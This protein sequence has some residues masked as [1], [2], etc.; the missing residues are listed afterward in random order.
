MNIET[1]Y[2]RVGDANIAYQVIG[3]GAIDFVYVPCWLSH[4]DRM[5]REPRFARFV[6]RLS[7]FGR[8]ILFDKR[9]TGLSDPMSSAMQ[10]SFEERMDDLQAVLDAAGSTHAV[11]FGTSMGGRLSALYAA[12]HPDR[13]AGLILMG[14]SA[15]GAHAPDY[16]WAP[17]LDEHERNFEHVA[18]SWGGP[19]NLDRYAASMAGDPEFALWWAECLRSGGGPAAAVAMLRLDAGS[20]IRP[21]LHSI[22]APALVLHRR[23]DKVVPIEGGRYLAEH[24][25]GAYFVELPGN[26]HL[27][28]VGDQDALFGEI[29][30]FVRD[31]LHALRPKRTLATAVAVE[32]DGALEAASR[33]GSGQWQDT[34]S[35]A[36]TS[37]LTAL[38][39]YRGMTASDA[40]DGFVAAFDTPSRAVYFAREII[41]VARRH[42]LRARIGL[43]TGPVEHSGRIVGGLAVELATRIAAVARTG[44]ILLSGTL[45]G[46]VSGSGLRSVAVDRDHA[47]LPVDL[48]LFRL[49]DGAVTVA[50]AKRM[51]AASFGEQVDELSPREREVALLVARGLSNRQVGA[52]LEISVSTVERHVANILLKLGY[53]SRAQLSLWAAGQMTNAALVVPAMTS[54][55]AT[56]AAD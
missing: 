34:R 52:E 20:D 47:G 31:R 38:R 8:V 24:I 36:R 35:S 56:Y 49:D 9:G 41:D 10:P 19:V 4:L 18:Q 1:N 22:T 7:S 45:M 17:S 46:L 40:G 54:R 6:E 2:A 3:Q 13:V 55:Y 33:S 39:T 25:T 21:I 27:A 32:F 23:G 28:F 43:H 44:E 42:G 11:L 51:S 16:P 29:G 37:V 48:R 5:W 26:D 50:P 15:R 53:R 14:S 12:N 30:R